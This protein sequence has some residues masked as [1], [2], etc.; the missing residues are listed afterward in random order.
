MPIPARA[1][2][3][4]CAAAIAASAAAQQR[5]V[6]GGAATPAPPTVTASNAISSGR[7]A[8]ASQANPAVANL[9]MELAGL[10]LLNSMV[11]SKKSDSAARIKQ[12]QAFMESQ[13]LA[14]D[15]AAFKP[16]TAFSPVS[17][18]QAYQAALDQV[19]LAGPPESKITD[20]DT[21]VREVQATTSMTHQS[22]DQLNE[23][24]SAVHAMT[25]FLDRSGKM[26]DYLRWSAEYNADQKKQEMDRLA[27]NRA[28]ADDAARARAARAD[29]N[30][31]MLQKKL[32]SM[33]YST[34]I[35]YNYTFSQGVQPGS[36]T[37][38]YGGTFFNG[39][40]D[41]Y[42]DI[43]NANTHL[44]FSQFGPQSGWWGSAP[45]GF[46]DSNSWNRTAAPVYR[47]SVANTAP[48][49]R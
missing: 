18:N 33:P 8:A 12:M 41:P 38:Y 25:E 21:L 30:I 4:L 15:F 13:N 6:R 49:P 42:Y 17:F 37:G 22:W 3:L 43:W 27:S 14:A 40:A 32:D 19:Q 24:L 47:S 10:N 26:N 20:L 35:D 39:Y 36:Q 46:Y 1:A 2:A 48:A 28:A 5:P 11:G 29:R 31:Q 45:G 16:S 23:N 7:V 9:Q 44:N 34:G